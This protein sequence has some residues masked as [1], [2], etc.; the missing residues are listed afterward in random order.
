MC[1]CHDEFGLFMLNVNVAS[2]CLAS[3]SKCC[4]TLEVFALIVLPSTPS[5][6]LP[7]KIHRVFEDGVFS[8]LK[9]RRGT[10]NTENTFV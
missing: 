2:T 3:P 8:D 7:A 10:K 5:A 4:I 6:L 1:E 9:P